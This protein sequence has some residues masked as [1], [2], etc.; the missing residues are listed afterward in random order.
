M[1]SARSSATSA[2]HRFSSS[3]TVSNSSQA[4]GRANL[5]A[6]QAGARY[7]SAT[8]AWTRKSGASALVLMRNG[9][10]AGAAWLS[11]AG[12]ASSVWAG[13]T[14]KRGLHHADRA[15][16]ALGRILLSSA[17]AAGAWLRRTSPDVVVA[18]DR[19]N[20]ACGR[21]MVRMGRFFAGITGRVGAFPVRL[22]EHIPAMRGRLL[23]G[24]VTATLIIES[25]LAA[26]M[27]SQLTGSAVPAWVFNASEPLV[28]PF[29]R[30]DSASTLAVPGVFQYST[31]LAFE[32]Y[33]VTFIVIVALLYTLP[34]LYFA[35]KR[36]AKLMTPVPSTAYPRRHLPRRYVREADLTIDIRTVQPVRREQPVAPAPQPAHREERVSAQG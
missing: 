1:L 30:F 8:G 21:G 24:P 17:T 35:G 28:A 34:A 10:S 3:T 19:A 18:I 6:Q 11:R 9:G 26:R 7:L 27:W 20:L 12:A 31:L 15:N 2:I 23:F 14:G 29:A 25:L 33:L 36:I 4:F 22:I 13:R 32:V 16:T 5:K